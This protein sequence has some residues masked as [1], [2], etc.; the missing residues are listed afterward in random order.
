MKNNH[1][2]NLTVSVAIGLLVMACEKNEV[3][4]DYEK[5][6]TSTATIAEI[7]VS[8]EEPVAGEEVTVTL[9]Y[10]NLSEDPAKE[11][12][13]LEKVG[14]DSFSDLT[15]V[16]ESSAQVDEEITRTFTYMVPAVA[17][18][19]EIALDMLLSSQKEFPQRER[20]MFTVQ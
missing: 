15:T 18:G 10:V 3:V 14:D 12:K 2:F 9:Y 20:V 16:D 17:A 6:G 4:P 7:S 19:T 13:V 8:N 1:I 5:V 11:I